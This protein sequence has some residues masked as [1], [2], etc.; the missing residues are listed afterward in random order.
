[1][2]SSSGQSLR[3]ATGVMER[4]SET[5]TKM[6]HEPVK[7]QRHLAHLHG[8]TKSY[9]WSSENSRAFGFTEAVRYKPD[10]TTWKT[11]LGFRNRQD[12][13]SC[14]DTLSSHD[15]IP[16]LHG[17]RHHPS[18]PAVPNTTHTYLAQ[19]ARRRAEALPV[20]QRVSFAGDLRATREQE[21]AEL[22][23]RKGEGV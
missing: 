13:R 6:L 17:N 19:R 12:E 4:V 21:S 23:A 3:A 10:T 18:R 11:N 8:D 16:R 5:Q 14:R 9:P 15:F 22:S 20:E 7:T 1:M 2:H